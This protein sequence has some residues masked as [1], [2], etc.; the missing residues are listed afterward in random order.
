MQARD[1][2]TAWD[3][4]EMGAT[5]DYLESANEAADSA[6]GAVGTRRRWQ[7]EPGTRAKQ[8]QRNASV[9]R[10]VEPFR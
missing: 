1:V 6:E 10:N 8:N 5:V 4:D 9:G 3:A 7:E 2:R